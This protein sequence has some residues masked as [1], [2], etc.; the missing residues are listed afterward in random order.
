MKFRA[1]VTVRNCY[2]RDDDLADDDGDNCLPHRDACGNEGSA[3]LPV[4][5]RNLVDGPERYKAEIVSQK[6][7]SVEMQKMYLRPAG[8]GSSMRR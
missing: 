7:R 2:Q 6:I 4:G 5:E 8:P 1:Y 3:E